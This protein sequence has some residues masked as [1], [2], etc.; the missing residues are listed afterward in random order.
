MARCLSLETYSVHRANGNCVV[1][2]E[3]WDDTAIQAFAKIVAHAFPA[4]AFRRQ[5]GARQ[6]GFF[7][8]QQK[9]RLVGK[10]PSGGIGQVEDF[11][12]L[13]T[14]SLT[15][16]D[17]L[18]ESHALAYH[19]DQDDTTGSLRRSAL[20]QLVWDAKYNT[21]RQP[22]ERIG[23]AMGEFIGAHPRYAR[24]DFIAAIPPHDASKTGGLPAR[25]I[26]QLEEALRLDVVQIT[27]VS[28]R[29]PQ[30]DITDEDRSKG[31]GRR[32]GNQRR[33]M[34]VDSNLSGRAI[35]VI[36]DLY[37]SGGSMQEAARA[38]REAGASEVLGLAATKQRLF[39][40]VSLVSRV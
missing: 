5:T 14:R 3:A 16:E 24:A 23:R 29:P 40:G 25:L 15:I 17:S 8:L 20:G 2:L 1:T 13:V 21:R 38:L 12:E 22:R 28:T 30:K 18:D 11:L 27:R 32:I 36:D 7:G 9:L 26:R 37:G 19:Q 6:T 35:I 34:R 10:V 33:S 4:C 31:V 39:E